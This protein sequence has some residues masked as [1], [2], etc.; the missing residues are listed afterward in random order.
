[1]EGGM[2]IPVE[3]RLDTGAVPDKESA[4]VELANGADVRVDETRPIDDTVDNSTVT[5]LETLEFVKGAL[6]VESM[7]RLE[8]DEGNP[9]D[10]R[11]PDVKGG[12]RLAVP[13]KESDELL[14]QYQL[15][16]L[17]LCKYYTATHAKLVG[18][19]DGVVDRH[20]KYGAVI[21]VIAGAVTGFEM[22]AFNKS[23]LIVVSS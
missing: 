2:S 3:A 8:P 23:P 15:L 11:L 1:M 7:M 5:G 13:G 10:T 14:R 21:V 17:F 22:L 16:N 6:P 9:D 18:L 4:E 19:K 12:G 20:E